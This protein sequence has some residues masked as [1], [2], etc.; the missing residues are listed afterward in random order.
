MGN[1][2]ITIRSDDKVIH[3]DTIII[4]IITEAH[5]RERIK[6]ESLNRTE[7]KWS[8]LS[9]RNNMIHQ[10]SQAERRNNEKAKK[11]KII[12]IK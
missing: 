4:V 6:R 8:K 3:S 12:R 5:D 9:L 1:G 7:R 10:E 2:N 11:E